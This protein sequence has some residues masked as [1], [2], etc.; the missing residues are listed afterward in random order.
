MCPLMRAFV[1]FFFWFPQCRVLALLASSTHILLIFPQ[2]EF[3][4]LEL[5]SN[6]E[7]ANNYKVGTYDLACLV[8]SPH[9]R[10]AGVRNIFERHG[11]PGED[12]SHLASLRHDSWWEWPT[13]RAF[14]ES[15]AGPLQRSDPP[16]QF[17]TQSNRINISR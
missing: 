1:L 16:Y 13:A 10:L 4:D 7:L 17:L 11:W 14:N 8:V 3:P 5:P 12:W 15:F 2:T 9:P 6:N